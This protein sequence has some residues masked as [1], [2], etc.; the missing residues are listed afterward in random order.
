MQKRVFWPPVP[1][2]AVIVTGLAVGSMVG[3][4]SF[5]E[6]FA[7]VFGGATGGVAKK[8]PEILGDSLSGG[9]VAA[10][11]T[12]AIAAIGGGGLGL[13]QLIKKRKEKN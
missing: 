10:I 12:A 5:M 2:A 3:C 11:V 1:S 6:G 8:A 4:A 9:I 13:R 7:A